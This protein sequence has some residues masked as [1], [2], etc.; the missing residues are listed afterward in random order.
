MDPHRVI[1]ELIDQSHHGIMALMDEACLNVGKITDQILLDAMDDKLKSKKHYSSKKVD[2]T[3]NKSLEFGQD[4][5][6]KHYAGD[7]VYNINGFIEKNKDTLFQDFKRLLFNS[8]NEIFQSM[9]PEGAHAIT[10]TTKRPQTAGTLF[11]TSMTSLMKTLASKEPF[12]V[13]CIKPNE[14]KSPNAFDDERVEHQVR[15]LGL[16]ENVRV[17]RAGFAFRQEY[18]KFNLRYKIICPE[19]WPRY[20]KGGDRDAVQAILR[21]QKIEDD[22]TFGNTKIFIQS[23]ETIFKLEQVRESKI[24][25]V[26]IILQKH[27]RGVLARR[28]AKRMKAAYKIGLYY[29]KYKLRTFVNLLKATFR[30]VKKSQDLGKNLPWPTAPRTLTK[31]SNLLHKAFL[32]WRAFTILSKYPREDWPEM[33][34]KITALE[35]LR[36]KRTAWGINRK[37]KAD[38]LGDTSENLDVH[39]YRASLG[40]Q[41]MNTKGVIFSALTVKYNRHDKMNERAIVFTKDNKILKM[42]PGKK[43]KNMQ[44]FQFSDITGL[45]LSPDEGNGLVL[46]HLKSSNDLVL[47]LQSKKG[48]DLTGELVGIL[49]DHYLKMLGRPLTVK[50]SNQMEAKSGKRC[51]VVSVQTAASDG[52]EFAKSANG[53]IIYNAVN[54]H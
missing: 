43:F 16:L 30:D 41:G 36:G 7:V 51:K 11:K 23:P 39:T 19:T 37:W 29:R 45:S 18:T 21:H 13:R 24:P 9:W 34:L 10:K 12:Y 2:T 54:G 35:L 26:V 8:N 52:G 22:C 40:K 5:V 31:T 14:I 38:Y 17:R 4:F 44:T 6:I 25:A 33:H 49:A 3:K 20:T 47:S 50:V 28:H 53:G 1:C 27:L 46:I 32:R 48:E 15:Y 42:D